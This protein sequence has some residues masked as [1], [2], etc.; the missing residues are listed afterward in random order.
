[1][2]RVC[3]LAG[4]AAPKAERVLALSRPVLASFSRSRFDDRKSRIS[5]LAEENG[6]FSHKS[7][8]PQR[9]RILWSLA[10]AL[11]SHQGEHGGSSMISAA[12][13]RVVCYRGTKLRDDEVEVLL[14]AAAP[15]LEGNIDFG[16]FVSSVAALLEPKSSPSP[17]LS[18]SP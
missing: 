9:E 10:Y 8:Y 5:E 18:P 1:M 2:I 3:K 15:D 7:M 12:D 4:L 14:T 16:E 11:H 6:G 13:L 17:S